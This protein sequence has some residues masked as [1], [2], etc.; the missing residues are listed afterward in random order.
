MWLY[1]VVFLAAGSGWKILRPFFMDAELVEVSALNGSGQGLHVAC[2]ARKRGLVPDEESHVLDDDGFCFYAAVAAGVLG[3]HSSLPELQAWY[4][5]AADN[6]GPHV[7]VKTIPKIEDFWRNVCGMK[8]LSINLVYSDEMQRVI[9]VR[10][11]AD[12]FAERQVVLLLSH[13]M[14]QVSEGDA[15]T[16]TSSSAAE[17]VVRHYSLVK[18]PSSLFGRRSRSQVSDK[19]TLRRKHICWNCLNSYHDTYSFTS[20]LSYC[21]EN[22]CQRVIMPVKGETMHYRDRRTLHNTGE[23]EEEDKVT[24]DKAFRSAFTLFFDFEALH[25]SPEK[26]C[27]CSAEMVANR[28]EAEELELQF[29]KSSDEERADWATEERMLSG[30]ATGQREHEIFMARAEG[31]R[32]TRF[33]FPPECAAATKPK[34]ICTHKT[35][36]EAEQKAFA[37]SYC[38]MSRDGRVLDTKTVT[39]LEA[40]ESFLRDTVELAKTYLP[41]LSPGNDMRKMPDYERT[42]A[43]SETCCYLCKQEFD[44]TDLNLCRVLDHDHLSGEFLGV[45]HSSC[46]L[47]RREEYSLTCFS[48]NFSGYDSHFLIKALSNVSDAVYAVKAIPINTQKFK[49]LTINHRIRFVDSAAFLNCSL[50]ACADTLV[51]SGHSFPLLNE[52]CNSKEQKD[53]LLR[54]GVYPYS[55]ATSVDR[56]R[57]TKELPPRSSFYNDLMDQDI[58]DE[59]YK[60]AKRVWEVFKISDMMEY[61][62]LYLRTD[63]LLLAEAV[64]LLRANMWSDFNLDIAKY[65]S[66]PM[67]AKDIMLK[68]TGVEL[69]LIHD[70]EMSDLI[71]KSL[72]GGLSY[73]NKRKAEKVDKKDSPPRSILY[74]DCTNLYGKA[75]CMALPTGGFEWMKREEI[76]ALCLE[77]DISDDSDTGYF[78][79][80][81]LEYP[82]ELHEEHTSFPLAAQSLELSESDLSPYSFSCLQEIKRTSKYRAKKLTSTFYPRTNYLCHGMNLKLYLRLGLRLV[83]IRRA[84]K[85]RQERFIKPYIEMCSERR[86]TAPTEAQRDMYKLLCNSLYGKLIEGFEKRMNCMFN[87]D[88][89]TA[90]RNSSHPLFK[91]SVIC[92]EDLSISFH[93]KPFVKMNQCWAV[94]FSVLELSKFWMQSIFYDEIKPAFA[95]KGGCTVLMSDTDS[96]LLETAMPSTDEA[97]EVLSNIMDTSNYDKEH[98]LY[99]GERAKVPGF[100]KNEV[101]KDEIELFV[102]LK[103]KTYAIKTASNGLE[104]KAKGIPERHKC[105]IPLQEMLNCLVMTKNFS[106]EYKALRSVNHINQLV[107]SSRVAFSSFDDKRYLLCQVHSVPYGSRLIAVSMNRGRCYLCS[108]QPDDKLL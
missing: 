103:S 47:Q 28:K 69:E 32:R 54:K 22:S 85:F 80:V 37:Y 12:P 72:R 27:S 6:F 57:E 95:S 5:S 53:L 90:L 104:V 3:A 58:S 60:H 100:M 81:D 46:N 83:R 94:G 56:L 66:L 51:K 52:L 15:S 105:K 107:K 63:T 67:L 99:S 26:V 4:S 39:S 77:T 11:G 68:T 9:P 101:P 102:G 89:V 48:H 2:Y 7:D 25:V 106:V 74:T 31:S 79:E 75:M 35:R 41:D 78:F 62:N 18:D 13:S 49:C 86:K 44:E 33:D 42:L 108:R 36:V 34:R 14:Q 10:A 1:V 16:L 8:D 91:G 96:F 61:T 70:Q 24:G 93:K 55:Y 19:V 73:I 88:R 23:C 59:D 76:E 82:E 40:G 30:E 87:R 45:A 64:C 38:L 43:L 17:N 21:Q 84:I 20:H 97:V 65:L 98:R 92:D 29:L 71:Q 50:A